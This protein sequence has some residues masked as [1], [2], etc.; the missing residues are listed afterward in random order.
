MNLI[1]QGAWAT[2]VALSGTSAHSGL[3]R[4]INSSIPTV[5]QTTCVIGNTKLVT[6]MPTLKQQVSQSKWATRAWT[7][8]EAI[9][10]PRC[11]YFTPHQVYF[12]CNAWQCCESMDETTSPFHNMSYNERC[13]MTDNC[14]CHGGTS[15]ALGTG[16]FRDP[17]CEPTDSKIF[18]MTRL[19]KYDKLIRPYSSRDMTY[20]SDALNSCDGVL[21]QMERVW[22]KE[23]F[24]WG[25]PVNWLA[26][27]LL[28]AHKGVHHRRAGFPSWSWTGWEG[29]LSQCTSRPGDDIEYPMPFRAWKI[30]S[31]E[32][33]LLGESSAGPTGGYDPIY[34][35]ALTL[36]QEPTY[37]L[38]LY[39]ETQLSSLLFVDAFLFEMQVLETTDDIF[40]WQN[41]DKTKFTVKA[42]GVD[43]L[44]VCYN[45]ETVPKVRQA[46]HK[47][48]CL[49]LDRS[50]IKECGWNYELLLLEWS[51]QTSKC[52]ESPTSHLEHQVGELARRAGRLRLM[53]PDGRNYSNK[54]QALFGDRNFHTTLLVLE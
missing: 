21:R 38:G 13:K 8:Q 17:M 28:W 7:Y 35:A 5:Q 44:L 25:L 43:C 42:N 46:P 10:S 26:Y 3:P 23:G 15:K 24:F 37:D 49:L 20:P 4:I 11:L 14:I 12:E 54:L 19:S 30:E 33:C 34:A 9:L 52:E 40:P 29:E 6:V 45:E 32:L 1:Y 51:R 16:V 36:K 27:T 2:I 47:L 39:S 22:F 18:R 50:Y 48:S 41:L 53:M 31:G